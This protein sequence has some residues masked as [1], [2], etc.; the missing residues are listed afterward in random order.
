MPGLRRNHAAPQLFEGFASAGVVHVRVAR[1]AIWQDTHVRRAARIG[2]VCQRHVAHLPGQ[3]RA[4][5]REQSNRG[6]GNF[7][8]KNDGDFGFLFERGF[9]RDELLHKFVAQLTFFMR[10]PAQCRSFL[11]RCYLY[12]LRGFAFQLDFARS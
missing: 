10:H 1:Q 12:I 8:A 3:L 6:A 5:R 9:Q 11:A 7:R 2:V 4:E